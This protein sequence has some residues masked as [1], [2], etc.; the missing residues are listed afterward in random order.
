MWN[1]IK[2]DTGK[3]V[4]ITELGSNIPKPIYGYQRENAEEEG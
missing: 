1:L 4:H 3:L 2:N